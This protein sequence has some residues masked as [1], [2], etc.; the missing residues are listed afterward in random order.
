MKHLRR[1]GLTLCVASLGSGIFLACSDDGGVILDTPDSGLDSSLPDSARDSNAPDSNQPDVVVVDSGIDATDTTDA[2]A[3]VEVPIVDAGDP[4]ATDAAALATNFPNRVATE[5]CRTTA[6]CCFGNADEQ[7]DASVDGGRYDQ[8]RCLT[9]RTGVGIDQSNP[10]SSVDFS[11]LSYNS[12]KANECLGRIQVLSCGA[13]AAEYRAA[14][15][16]CY[17]ALQG[18]GG[19]GAACKLSSECQP[20]FFCNTSV[21]GGSCAAIRNTGGPCGDWTTNTAIA[22]NS[23]SNRFSGNPPRFCGTDDNTGAAIKDAAAWTCNDSMPLGSYCDNDTWCSNSVCVFD[24]TGNTSCQGF[25]SIF[26]Q[27]ACSA[28][29]KH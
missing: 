20:G 25:I 15:A 12:D 4:D 24:S 19:A 18:T 3:D 23:C 11:K 17:A 2:Q 13:N 8:Q 14:V 9:I 1:L 21:G 26:N 10:G 7:G 28:L 22:Q 27:A 6:R 29:V 5:M 16:A